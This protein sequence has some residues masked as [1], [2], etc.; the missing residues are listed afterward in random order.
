MADQRNPRDLGKAEEG[1]QP[2]DQISHHINRPQPNDAAINCTDGPPWYLG[3]DS[4]RDWP[5]GE[6]VTERIEQQ[7]GQIVKHVRPD[8]G[9][10]AEELGDDYFGEPPWR[11]FNKPN[12]G[13]ENLI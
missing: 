9:G 11:L 1:W 4:T 5:G 7:A 2:S 13:T 3:R 12:G 10:N 8:R 6:Q